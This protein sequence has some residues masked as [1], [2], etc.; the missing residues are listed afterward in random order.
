MAPRD[1]SPSIIDALPNIYTQTAE[2]MCVCV[3][4]HDDH[5][6]KEFVF[7]SFFSFF[8]LFIFPPLS[9]EMCLNEV[10]SRQCPALHDFLSS[11]QAGAGST[12]IFIEREDNNGRRHVG[13]AFAYKRL[14]SS[15]AS[16]WSHVDL[17]QDRKEGEREKELYG[18][19][20][21]VKQLPH[22]NCIHGMPCNIYLV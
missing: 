13:L 18:V 22:N 1:T 11:E 2:H 20:Y 16:G 7:L 19:A 4:C 15:S 8:F 10:E 12:A 5:R 6:K 17:S 3:Y 21:S 9:P 14:T